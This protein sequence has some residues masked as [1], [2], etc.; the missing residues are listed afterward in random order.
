MTKK[1]EYN[2]LIRDRIPE[3]IESEGKS[4]EIVM[5]SV[6]SFRC[7]LKKKLV[8][9]ANEAMNSSTKEDLLNEL[10]D[11][12]EVSEALMKEYEITDEELI[13]RKREKLRKNGGFE[14]R[15]F[16]VSVTGNED[17]VHE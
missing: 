9:E 5:L 3:I 15:L 4:H 13:A 8:E 10:A 16:L 11:V 6:Q 7:E 12:F 1:S 14:K 17:S 2:K